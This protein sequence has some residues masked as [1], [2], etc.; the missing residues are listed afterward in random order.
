VSDKYVRYDE[1]EDVLASTDLLRFLVPRLHEEPSLW[2]WAIIATQSALQGA[3]VC[4]L[5]DGT[6]ASVLTDKSAREWLE[7]LRGDHQ[8]PSPKKLRLADFSTLFRKCCRQIPTAKTLITRRH[9]S[10]VY[11]L[12][13]HFR[14]GFEHFQPQSW[15]IET[16]ALPSIIE[17]ALHFV[18]M[19]MSSQMV[20][21]RLDQ[22]QILRLKKQST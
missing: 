8:T 11:K 2:K 17:S 13:R 19:A 1:I 6:G 15:S 14:N 9:V 22:G 12:H 18:E 3:L 10:D 16:A 20:S 5:H 21:Y 4:A 7:W